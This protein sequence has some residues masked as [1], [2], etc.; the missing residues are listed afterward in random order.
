MVEAKDLEAPLDPGLEY[1]DATPSIEEL[2]KMCLN[3]QKAL[4]VQSVINQNM[5]DHIKKLTPRVEA[6]EEMNKIKSSIILPERLA[7]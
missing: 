3:L 1:F 5:I 6:L 7:N 2:G 4:K